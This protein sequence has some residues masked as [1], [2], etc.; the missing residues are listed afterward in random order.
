VREMADPLI[1]NRLAMPSDVVAFNLGAQIDRQARRTLLGTIAVAQPATTAMVATDQMERLRRIWF[2]LCRYSLWVMLAVAV[3]FIV[4]REEFFE[5]YLREKFEA[6]REAPLVLALLLGRYLAVFPNAAIGLVTVA[7]AKV[8]AS[9]LQAIGLEVTNLLLTLTLVGVCQMG[10][11]GAA[12]STFVVAMVLHP[13][14]VWRLGLRLTGSRFGEWFRVSVLPGVLPCLVTAPLWLFLR[15]AIEPQ[16]WGSLAL[17][18]VAGWSAYAVITLLLTDP[19]ERRD[20]RKILGF[21]R[22]K[23]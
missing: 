19:D 14:L 15:H 20:L 1:L 21:S 3:P 4:L 8:R 23:G 18:G 10:A 5:L 2:R 9:S 22:A 7:R 16:S 12:L 11:V 13:L 6:N 17:C